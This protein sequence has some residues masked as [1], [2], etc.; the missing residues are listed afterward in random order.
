VFEVFFTTKPSSLERE[1]SE[2]VGTGLGLASANYFVR[3]YGGRID[4]QSELEKGTTVSIRIPHTEPKKD[5]SMHRILLVDDSNTLLDILVQVCEE[6]D[7][8]VYAAMDGEK[9]LEL[10]QKRNPDLIVTDLCMPGL[11]GPEMMSRIR[12]CNPKQRVI[13]ISGYADNPEFREWLEKE[14]RTPTLSTVLK[15]P[16]SLENFRAVVRQMSAD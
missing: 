13:Y 15:K 14:A 5:G 6:M 2:P 12:E 4:I 9:A 11:T 1:G 10:Y 8:E 16:F 3:Q 7:L